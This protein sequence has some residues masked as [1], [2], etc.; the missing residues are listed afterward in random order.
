VL[1]TDLV[2]PRLDGRG[3]LQRL[4]QQGGP[5]AIVLTAY[6]SLDKA[7]STVKDL[8][9][10]WYLE[11]PVEMSELGALLERAASQ[12]LLKEE[13]ERLQRQ[14]SYQGVLDEMVGRS[15]AMQQ[16]FAQ[17]RQVASTALRC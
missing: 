2:M 5:P 7:V 9:A 14:L 6:G 17:V 12:S 13:A 10:F 1:I 3:L 11:K 16:V 15:A 4:R 8:G